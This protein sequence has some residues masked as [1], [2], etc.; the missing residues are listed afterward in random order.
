[1]LMIYSSKILIAITCFLGN[2]QSNSIAVVPWYKHTQIKRRDIWDQ[3]PQLP[4]CAAA[5]S[6]NR[7]NYLAAADLEIFG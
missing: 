7:S 1:M 5:A 2:G 4:R 3:C 6:R